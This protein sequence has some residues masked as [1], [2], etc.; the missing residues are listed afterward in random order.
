M[1][2]Y[3]MVSGYNKACLLV[4][5][6]LGKHPEEYPR[7]RDCFVGDEEHPEYDG[8]ILVYTRVGG[9]NR[10][11][12]VDEIKELR[13]MPGYVTDYND[14]FDSTYASFVF[15][16]PEKYVDD[17]AKL[18][19]GCGIRDISEEYFGVI[20]KTYPKL[21]DNLVTIRRESENGERKD[22]V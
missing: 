9:G 10:E 8:K 13:K 19:S 5:P 3:N 16:V 17:F 18:Q 12:H 14:S 2:L 1:S 22:T 21:A 7:F 20:V 4:L 6:M 11:Y 15:D